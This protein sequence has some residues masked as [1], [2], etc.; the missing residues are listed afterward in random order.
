M[1]DRL[2]QIDKRYR[3]LNRQ[4]AKPEIASDLNQLQKLAQERAG[5]EGV[6][7]KYREYR[8][9]SKE[10][11]DVKSMHVTG[12]DEEMTALVKE[13]TQNL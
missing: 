5:I 13:E 10:L 2:E 4:M 1:L 9:A 11:E 3:E 6:V 8:K 7:T 12:S